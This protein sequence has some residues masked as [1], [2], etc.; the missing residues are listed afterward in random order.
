MQ[1]F[2]IRVKGEIDR[3]WAEWFDNM[4]ITHTLEGDTVLSGMVADQAAMYGVLSKL[5]DLG[6]QLISVVPTEE[7]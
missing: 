4:T 3:N 6:M 7:G 5:R 1:N 2:Q